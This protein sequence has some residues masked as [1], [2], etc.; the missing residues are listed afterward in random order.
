MTSQP[1]AADSTSYLHT[2]S[3]TPYT[4]S[5]LSQCLDKQAAEPGD[6]EAYVVRATGAPRQSISFGQLKEQ[7]DHLASSLIRLGLKERSKV[8]LSGVSSIEYVVSELAIIR[9]GLISVRTSLTINQ[10]SQ[11]ALSRIINYNS[12]VALLYY[13]G[14]YGEHQEYLEKMFPALREAHSAGKVTVETLPTLQYFINM[15]HETSTKVMTV[16]NL[17]QQPVDPAL[18]RNRSNGVEADDIATITYTPGSET[19]PKPVPDRKSVV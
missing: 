11:Q 17:L 15:R 8:I 6:K 13:P 14:E 18:V 7:V 19:K 4:A 1:A 10:I 16:G 2:P 3:T 12:A 9:A 5:T